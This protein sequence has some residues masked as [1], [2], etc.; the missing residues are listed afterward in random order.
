MA[1]DILE[2]AL[3]WDEFVWS[4]CADPT[5]VQRWLSMGGSSGLSDRADALAFQMAMTS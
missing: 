1:P 3:Q 5:C 4:V 2:G